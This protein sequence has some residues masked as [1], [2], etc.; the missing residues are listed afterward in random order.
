[1][2]KKATYTPTKKQAGQKLSVKLTASAKGY[3]PMTVT[4]AAV[5]I[6]KPFPKAGKFKL[7]GK[8]KTGTVLSLTTVAK[9]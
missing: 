2:G 6:M 4:S 3:A 9:S 8:P 1:V 7:T 5:K